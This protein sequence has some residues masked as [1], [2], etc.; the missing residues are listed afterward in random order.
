M[1]ITQP[2]K[3]AETTHRS[4]K[5]KMTN[6]K[7]WPKRPRAETTLIQKFG[8]G[9]KTASR[10]SCLAEHGGKGFFNFRF[11]IFEKIETINSE[12]ELSGF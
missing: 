4:T 11:R 1:E 9:K 10:G 8:H 3:L 2:R 5:G 7:N 6:P 12:K